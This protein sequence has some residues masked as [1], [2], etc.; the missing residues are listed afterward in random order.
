VLIELV[1]QTAAAL[2]GLREKKKKEGE[3]AT[4]G[5]LVGI[6]SATFF[7]D[8]IPL[9]CRVVTRSTTRLLLENLKEITGIVKIDDTVVAEVTLQSVSC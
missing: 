1:A 2:G 3:S 9:Y 7:L 4:K 5:L 6:K 8:Q